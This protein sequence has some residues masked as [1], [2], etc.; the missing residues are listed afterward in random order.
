MAV[1]VRERPKGSGDWWIFIDHQ[2]TR[3]AKKVGKDK[4]LALEAARKIGTILVLGDMGIM[5]EQPKAPTFKEYA[6]KWLHGY[7][8]GLRRQSTFERYRDVLR[9]HIYPTLGSRPIDKIGR[10]EIR[11]L[12]LRLHGGKEKRKGLS[13]SSICL[14]RDVIGGPLSFALDE[15]LIPSNPASGITKKLQLRRDRKIV[16][17]PLTG[18]EVALFLGTCSTHSPEHYPFFLCAFRTGM[19]LGELLGLQ[20]SD[21]DGYGKFIKVSRS[22]KLGALTPTKTGKVRR[23][24]MSDQLIETLKA[25]HGDR[26]R[27]A[28]GSG[29]GEVIETIF[30]RGGK[31]MEQNHIRRVFKRLLVKAGLREIRLHDTRHTFASL[32]L[33]DGASPVYVKEQ[34]GHTSIQMTVDIYGHLIPSSNRERVNRL[35]TQLSAT[36]PQPAQKGKA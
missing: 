29:T 9:R 27:E 17:E 33:S 15:E 18:E 22:Y 23:V 32:L 3:K 13:R 20:W 1:K 30:H 4:K 6:E 14:I 11:E 2:G 5:E 24:D 36:Q 16:I 28:L 7:V 26:K 10:G 34:L 31:H 21:V 35:D 8:K 12:L 19:R 25:L